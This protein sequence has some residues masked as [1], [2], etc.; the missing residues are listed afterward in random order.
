MMK[1]LTRNEV[2]AVQFSLPER[3]NSAGH[4]VI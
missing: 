2:S 1:E 3:I 4:D